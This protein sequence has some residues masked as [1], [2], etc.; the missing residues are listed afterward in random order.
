MAVIIGTDP[1]KRSTTIEVIYSAGHVLAVGRYATDTVDYA[2]ILTAGS[3]FANRVWA[4]QGCN[5]ISRHLAHR[6]VHDGETV[7]DVPV[8]LSVQVRVFATGNGRKTEPV[9]AHSTAV[10]CRAR[11]RARSRG[12][13]NL[14]TE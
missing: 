9:D 6:L 2:E 12:S 3:R 7:V 1:H 4:V 14:I 13:A 5:G 11:R 10:S 8:K